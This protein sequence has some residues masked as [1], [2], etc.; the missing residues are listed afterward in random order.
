VL[1]DIYNAEEDLET[2]NRIENDILVPII[3]N[4]EVIRSNKEEKR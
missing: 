2:H 1:V 4:V 3:S